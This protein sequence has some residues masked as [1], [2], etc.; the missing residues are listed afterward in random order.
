MKKIELNEEELEQMNYNDIA[1]IVLENKG[2]KMK[3]MDLF[4]EIGKILHLNSDEYSS[5]VTDLFELLSTDKRFI[6][7]EQGYWDLRIKHN[8]GIVMDSF[9]EDE[10]EILEEEPEEN[11][12]D[13]DEE[14]E[15]EDDDIE[16]DDLSDLVIIDDIDD[17]SNM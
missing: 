17:E 8:K 4:T 13:I 10:E 7:L 12:F 5:H 3:I 6:M 11:N 14:K 1:Y 16:E 15:D 9:D 2:K